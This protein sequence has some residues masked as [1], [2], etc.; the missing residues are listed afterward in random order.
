MTEPLQDPSAPATTPPPS[1]PPGPTPPAAAGPDPA[2]AR[3]GG[4]ALR[5]TLPAAIVAALLAVF[6]PRDVG[7]GPAPGGAPLDAQG[8]PT[9]LEEQLAPVTLV[10]FWAT[11]CAPCITE[12]PLLV[13]LERDLR[14]DPNFRLLFIA[15]EDDPAQ[16]APFLG[17]ELTARAL[18]DPSWETARKWGTYKLPETHLV[19]DGNVVERWVGAADWSEPE[20][21]ARLADAL[22]QVARSG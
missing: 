14:R 16:F 20:I 3:R 19:V 5:I 8:A 4:W 11:W 15:V 6:W 2:E 18:H 7:R 22:A 10:H 9:P 21:R 17:P 13:A 1:A 12:I